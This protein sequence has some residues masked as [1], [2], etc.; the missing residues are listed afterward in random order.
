MAP[1]LDMVVE[2]AQPAEKTRTLTAQ[3]ITAA[4]KKVED[5]TEICENLFCE[6]TKCPKLHIDELFEHCK[7]VF[8]KGT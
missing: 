8:G 5:G 7:A 2:A 6:G 3:E 1:I 4:T